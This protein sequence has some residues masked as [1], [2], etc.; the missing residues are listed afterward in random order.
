MALM[1]GGNHLN[2]ELSDFNKR[3]NIGSCD[4]KLLDFV[5]KKPVIGLYMSPLRKVVFYKTKT[6]VSV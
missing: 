4:C 5:K 2:L 3:M 1:K 6:L